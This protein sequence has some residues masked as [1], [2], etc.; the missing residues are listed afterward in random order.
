M[1]WGYQYNPY[2]LPSLIPLFFMVL[3]G[4]HCFRNRK[5]PGAA[6][7]MVLI[8]LTILWIV[9]NSFGLSATEDPARIFW[10]KFEKAL[11]LP[12]AG[13]ALCFVLAYAGLTRW[14]NRQVIGVLILV[15]LAFALLIFTNDI[16]Q[17]VWRHILSDGII[18]TEMG[19]AHWVAAVYGYALGL[20]QLA[21][22]IWLFVRSPRHRWIAA[23][24]ILG[25]VLIRVAAYL[26]ISGNN[27]FKPL[28]FM[29][30]ASNLTF[31]LYALAFFRLNMFEL[32]P[33]AR[34]AVIDR[35]TE[36][37]VVLDTQKYI[38]DM[39]ETAERLLNLS[40][41][42]AIGRQAES[43]LEAFPDMVS[44]IRDSETRQTELSFAGPYSRWYHISIS[45]LSD[46]RALLLGYLIW[47]RDITEQK[48]VQEQLLDNQ[49]TNAMLQERELLG[50]ELHDGI[51]QI[52]AAAQLQIA[53][54]SELLSRGETEQAALYMRQ[55][56][57]IVQE[58]KNAI[59]TYLAGVK[60]L[61]PSE[62]G[63]LETLRSHIERYSRNHNIRIEFDATPE[64][65]EI[66]I[67]ASVAAQIHTIVQEALTNVKRHANARL[68]NVLLKTRGNR[69][70][71]MIEDDGQGFDVSAA[72]KHDAFGLRSMGGRAASVGGCLEM[73]SIPGKGTRIN[74]QV[75]LR[76]EMT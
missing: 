49:R 42:Q 45:P 15:P 3:L 31:L 14:L 24:L 70:C 66:P 52:L 2:V 1:R 39:N 74:V 37:M 56:S 20:V 30:L 22:L 28:N 67:D 35:M 23:G 34:N 65:Q 10:F 27:P 29:I 76:K 46:R 25:L 5:V 75:P 9:A 51:G 26:N 58:A 40:R 33:I 69:L 59:R 18:R 71:I 43:V 53:S 32:V 44:L 57:G 12:I 38:S 61:T 19:P 8:G 48:R 16:H 62:N 47:I 17:L 60:A 68:V 36:A 11:V 7:F 72:G 21:V 6:P 63:F 4:I 13:A 55:L 41:K 50:R 64:V 73:T 54:A